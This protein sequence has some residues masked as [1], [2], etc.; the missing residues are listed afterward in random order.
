MKA[1]NMAVSAAALHFR[2]TMPGIVSR[3]MPGYSRHTG[4]I[5]YAELVPPVSEDALDLSCISRADA[6]ASACWTEACR[7]V[8][9]ASLTASWLCASVKAACSLSL[10]C[11]TSVSLQTV[12]VTNQPLY[13]HCLPCHRPSQ[14]LQLVGELECSSCELSHAYATN[15]YLKQHGCKKLHLWHA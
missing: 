13:T 5:G 4:P 7:L 9:L 1:C 6:L 2:H 12:R 8:T 14:V 3:R 15:A 10:L 11:S